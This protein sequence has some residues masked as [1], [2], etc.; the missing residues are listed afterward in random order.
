MDKDNTIKSWEQ[1]LTYNQKE[2]IIKE[3]LTSLEVLLA[4][5]LKD[6]LL[7]KLE[8]A[9]KR[10]YTLYVLPDGTLGLENVN[11]QSTQIVPI[12]NYKKII[13]EYQLMPESLNALINKLTLRYHT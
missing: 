2:N 12:Q 4:T 3:S 1:I 13:E 11:D 8:L 5:S 6:G 7:K 10:P 9:M